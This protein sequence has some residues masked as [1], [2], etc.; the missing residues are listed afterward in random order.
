MTDAVLLLSGGL[1]SATV[2]ALLASENYSI[3]A[4]TFNYGQRHSRELQ[5]ARSV[6]RHF[7]MEEHIIIDLNLSR[8]GGSALTDSSIPLPAAG[9]AGIPSTYVPA[10]NTVFLSIALGLAE[11]RGCGSIYTGVNAV[12]YSGY[13]DCRPEFIEA[14]NR[15]S[16]VATKTGV[17]GS[18]VRVIAP[19]I[20][21]KKSDIVRLG[22][23]RG[24]PYEL[25][26]SCYKGGEKACGVCDSCIL[27]LN[28][29]RDAGMEDPLE[30]ENQ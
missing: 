13:P 11:A 3:R 20:D 26:W 22:K 23:E 12:D 17:E 1:D 25:T 30:Y 4:L 24:A 19:L 7:S 27:R 5:A 15:L 21:M 10:R 6:A 16:S 29:F 8:I 18:P 9:G 28:G 2:A 14:F